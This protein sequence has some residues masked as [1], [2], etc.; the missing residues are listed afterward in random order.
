LQPTD[1]PAGKHTEKEGG[2]IM[3]KL[4]KNPNPQI[5]MDISIGGRA[6]ERMTFEVAKLVPSC[7]PHLII[8]E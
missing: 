1:A 3:P 5:F 6:A 8:L 2:E 7:L 4:K